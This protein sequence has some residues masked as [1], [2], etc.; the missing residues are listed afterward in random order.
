[1][2]HA[3]VLCGGKIFNVNTYV[4]DAECLIMFGGCDV[5]EAVATPKDRFVNG[6]VN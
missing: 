4:I 2:N 1:L 6:L 3:V 5:G